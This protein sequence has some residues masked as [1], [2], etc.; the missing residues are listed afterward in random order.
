MLAPRKTLW[1]T[2]PEVIDVAIDAL[3]I[4][5]DDI[6]FDIGAGDGRFL[7]T[8]AGKTGASCTGIEINEERVTE[9]LQRIK[10]ESLEDKCSMISGNA[11]EQD[12]STATVF[13][14][15]LIPRGLRI[16][17]P[18]LKALGKPLRVITYMAPF[19]E[20]ETPVETFQVTSTKHPDAQWPLFLY[21][22]GPSSGKEDQ[23]DIIKEA[24]IGVEKQTNC[25]DVDSC[26]TSASTL[27]ASSTSLPGDT[28]EKETVINLP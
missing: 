1:S 3:K 11:L 24:T 17:L 22:F 6:V 23:G 8:C 18:V 15:Y 5:A 28:S 9:A 27:T 21:N 25:V 4:N 7:T 19:P 16:I 10:E 12:Y 20:S 14:L 26:A 2:P 13:Y